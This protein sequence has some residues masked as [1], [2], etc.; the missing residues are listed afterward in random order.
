M[1][2]I[3][4][5]R[6]ATVEMTLVDLQNQSLQIRSFWM[7]N[8]YRMIFWL[9]E[10]IQNLC[11]AAGIDSGSHHDALELRFVD[12]LRAAESEQQTAGVY[13]SDRFLVYEF[14]TLQSTVQRL[15]IFR[16]RRRVEDYQIVLVFRHGLQVKLGIF[17]ETRV[18]FG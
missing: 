14:V 7:I 15:M 11:F 4:P 1:D 16:K 2:E 6:F 8:I 9:R 10:L 12:S 5:F 18:R 17:D 13:L 3:S